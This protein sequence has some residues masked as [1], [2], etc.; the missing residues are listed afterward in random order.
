M[1][2]FYLFACAYFTRLC[3]FFSRAKEVL[4]LRW[5]KF[6]LRDTSILTF[7][8]YIFIFDCNYYIFFSLIFLLINLYFK[9]NITFKIIKIFP[10]KCSYLAWNKYA[11]VTAENGRLSVLISTQAIPLVPTRANNSSNTCVHTW[12]LSTNRIPRWSNCRTA[13]RAS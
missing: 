1:L 13:K 11:T 5:L 10:W 2:Y 3:I 7:I 4:E 8:L 6:P 12:P 9:M